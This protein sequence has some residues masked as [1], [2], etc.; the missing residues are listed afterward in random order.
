MPVSYTHLIERGRHFC[1]NDAH[2][3]C[4]PEQIKSEFANVCDLI[5]EVYKDFNITDYQMCIRDR[6]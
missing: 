5:F 4:T 3:F 1:Q 2:L 6:C